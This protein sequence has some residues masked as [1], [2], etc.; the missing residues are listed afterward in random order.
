MWIRHTADNDECLVGSDS[1]TK[2]DDATREEKTVL[3]ISF[4]FS[5]FPLPSMY[6]PDNILALVLQRL[7]LHD[8]QSAAGTCR[9]W[10]AAARKKAS[11]PCKVARIAFKSVDFSLSPGARPLSQTVW[12]ACTSVAYPDRLVHSEGTLIQLE[13]TMSE[14]I[15]MRSLSVVF[16]ARSNALY[17]QSMK[18]LTALRTNSCAFVENALDAGCI[19]RRLDI[20]DT[21]ELSNMETWVRVLPMLTSLEHICI[22]HNTYQSIQFSRALA[23]LIHACHRLHTIELTSFLLEDTRPTLGAFFSHLREHGNKYDLSSIRSFLYV[24]SHPDMLPLALVHFPR[25][26]RFEHSAHHPLLRRSYMYDEGLSISVAVETHLQQLEL[27]DLQPNAGS[28]SSIVP[29]LL[30]LLDLTIYHALYP[31][32]YRT[33]FHACPHVQ[34]LYLPNTIDTAVPW[35]T[36]PSSLRYLSV[37]DV[38]IVTGNVWVVSVA[39][40]AWIQRNSI[41]FAENIARLD[42][43]EVIRPIL[44]AMV[45]S[46]RWRHV[47]WN[48]PHPPSNMSA[49][50]FTHAQLAPIRWYVA[51]SDKTYRPCIVYSCW[52]SWIPGMDT[53]RIVWRE[54]E[55]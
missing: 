14:L 32:D 18:H 15:H 36:L 46:P 13:K 51:G 26:I 37:D 44:S 52:R 34:R 55:L 16:C 21:R 9:V 8:F 31:I 23:E 5:F 1:T 43:F 45:R 11:W 22:G 39:S 42:Q 20:V 6:V 40:L 2:H 38:A 54:V 24:Q 47:T 30:G 17:Q 48:R 29:H 19:L 35:D 3:S 49:R 4:L 12:A 7:S 33:L 41:Q 53:Q 27:T 28:Y 10:H 25:L 50:G